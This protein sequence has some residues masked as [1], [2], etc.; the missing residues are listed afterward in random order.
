MPCFSSSYLRGAAIN[1]VPARGIRSKITKDRACSCSSE[2][3]REDERAGREEMKGERVGRGESERIRGSGGRKRAEERKE[4]TEG[5]RERKREKLKGTLFSPRV[6]KTK[7][8]Y[9]VASTLLPFVLFR[10]GCTS[11]AKRVISNCARERGRQESHPSRNAFCF[12][13]V[14]VC[15]YM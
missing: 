14:C 13:R 5:E 3:T 1:L 9:G 12:F 7:G 15:V 11:L 6:V 8:R 10:P 4:R 2:N